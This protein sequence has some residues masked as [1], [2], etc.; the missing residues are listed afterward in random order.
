MSD[1][2]KKLDARAVAADQELAEGVFRIGARY[3]IRTPT[4]HY[5]GVLTAVT[6]M[7]FVLSEHSTVFETG[8]FPQFFKT[9]RG[10]NHEDHV[11]ALECTIDRA[12]AH[13]MRLP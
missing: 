10:T 2:K 4:Y 1:A 8:A 5:V 9:G 11:G 7:C 12:G 3:Y 13:T 6:P